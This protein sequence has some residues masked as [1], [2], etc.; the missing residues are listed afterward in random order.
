M[1]G[2]GSPSSYRC[3]RSP[4]KRARRSEGGS[5]TPLKNIDDPRQRSRIDA[6][7]N[8][9]ATPARQHNLHP[10]RRLNRARR[11]WRVLRGLNTFRER[12]PTAGRRLAADH[13]LR[14]HRA[15][16]D[17]DKTPLSGQTAPR[18]QLARRQSIP[19]RRRR[20]LPPPIVAL[21][22]DPALLFQRPTTPGTSLDHL[23][24][25]HLRHSRMI[26]HT[27]MSSPPHPSHKAV[28]SAGILGGAI[29]LILIIET[30]RASCSHRDR[31]ARFGNE[32]LRGLV[33]A[34]Q[35]TIAVAWPR[36]DGQHVFHSGYERAVGLRRDDPVLAAMGLKSVFLSARPIVL[37]LAR[38][39]MPSST[40]LFSNNRKVQR[41]RPL[42]GLEQAKAISLASFSPSK[43]RATAGIARGL[44]V[45]TASKPSS[46]SCLRT[47]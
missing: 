15:I 28:L 35:R 38:S 19:P 47:R 23:K 43:I 18:E 30:G 21:A 37:S 34:N 16:V 27:P 7:V 22:H 40:T 4:T 46:T 2:S 13:C 31:H 1:P 41:A 42:G 14:K 11:G 26:S 29:A 5:L 17:L 6:V 36:I 25:R 20:Y 8:D 12:R 10:A 24:S 45:N 32:L 9:H 44:R 3:G 33:E 39:T